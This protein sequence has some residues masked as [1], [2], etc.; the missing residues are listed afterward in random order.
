MTDEIDFAQQYGPW[1]VVTG[2]AQG[3]GLG[4]AQEIASR[5]VSVVMLDRQPGVVD[6]AAELDG[7]AIGVVADL[8]DDSWA[9]I[10]T[11]AT[12]DLDIGLAVANAG[13]SFVGNFLDMDHAQRRAHLEINA[14]AAMELAAMYLPQMVERDKGGFVVTSSGSA[15]AGTGAV[16]LYSATKAFV[17]NLAEAVGWE[18]RNTGVHTLSF[19]GPTMDTPAFRSH[20]PDYSALMMPMLDPR[21]VVADVLDKLPDGGRWLPEGMDLMASL[22]REQ[23]VDIISS[24]TAALYPHIFGTADS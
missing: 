2:A 11:T 8:T 16:A 23:Q 20:N 1:A 10:L 5:G 14:G 9:D 15:I 22:P 24:S 3:V 12:A 13:I 17:M 21:E 19:C 6:I 18:L 7:E 4:F